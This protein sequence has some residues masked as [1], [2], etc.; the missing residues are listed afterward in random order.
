MPEGT[1]PD[2]SIVPRHRFVQRR[3]L[4]LMAFQAVQRYPLCLMMFQPLKAFP[5]LAQRCPVRLMS[6]QPCLEFLITAPPRVRFLV[7]DWCSSN[8]PMLVCRED[9]RGDSSS[10]WSGGSRRTG[11]AWH[12]ASVAHQPRRERMVQRAR[13]F[14]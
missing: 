1:G 5:M 11:R 4:Y 8:V 14:S 10:G 6:S 7:A 13:S 3:P 12:W 2:E 9:P